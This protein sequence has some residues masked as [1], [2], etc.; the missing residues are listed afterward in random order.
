MTKRENIIR[1]LKRQGGEHI[2]FELSFTPKLQKEF[3]QKTGTDN[4]AI[5]RKKSLVFLNFSISKNALS[6]RL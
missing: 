1:I 6:M 4:V 5:F 3:K 2:P